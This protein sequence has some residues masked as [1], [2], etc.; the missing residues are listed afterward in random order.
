MLDYGKMTRDDFEGEAFRAL[1]AV[2]G[3]A[4][5]G[6][7]AVAP[8][9]QEEFSFSV[10]TPPAQIRLPLMH[11]KPNGNGPSPSPP[12]KPKGNGLYRSAF[13]LLPWA[14][15]PIV[16]DCLVRQRRTQYVPIHSLENA[17][18]QKHIKRNRSMNAA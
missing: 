1:K 7:E 10:N 15:L 4:G 8:P 14:P 16:P 18:C 6:E 3:G 2:P 5:G 12:P 17:V 13:K 11:P 9:A